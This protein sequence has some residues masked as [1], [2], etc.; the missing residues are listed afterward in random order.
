MV[1]DV[2]L[3]L[4]ARSAELPGGLHVLRALPQARRSMVGPFV[5]L[6]QMGPVSGPP[7]NVAPHPHIGLSTVTDLFEGEAVHRDTLGSVQRITPGDVNWMTAGR[8][9]ARSERGTAPGRTFGIQ[10]RVALPKPHEE[11]CSTTRAS[12]RWWCAR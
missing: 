2:E 4:A 7:L 12:R 9:I 3:V 5:F 8:G 10:V 11:A 1:D 6:D